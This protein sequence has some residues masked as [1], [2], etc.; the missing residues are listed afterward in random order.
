[1][2]PVEDDRPTPEEE[3]FART[4]GSLSPRVLAMLEEHLAYNDGLV[5]IFLL[6]QLGQWYIESWRRRAESP[7]EYADARKVA[8]AIGA[9]FA[10]D[11]TLEESI[12]V[13]FVEIF[14][15]LPERDQSCAE[16]LPLALKAE[17]LKMK[18]WRPSAQG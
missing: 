13:G 7:E 16:N 2:D 4:L 6:S 18:A 3:E 10:E 14:V 9:R 1:M 8:E 12:A 11:A 5:F 17:Y 15:D